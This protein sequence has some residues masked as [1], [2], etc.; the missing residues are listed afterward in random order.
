MA[1]KLTIYY[2]IIFL[3]SHKTVDPATGLENWHGFLTIEVP[4]K[5]ACYPLFQNRNAAQMFASEQSC[6]PCHGVHIRTK[7][8]ALRI[9]DV[10]AEEQ[11]AYVAIDPVG[12]HSTWQICPVDEIR[13]LLPEA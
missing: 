1:D 3:A 9:L 2:P 13:S 12:H 7:A 10:A 8:R 4:G 11:V 6:G 5:G